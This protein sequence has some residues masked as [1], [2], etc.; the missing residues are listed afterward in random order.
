[1][2]VSPNRQYRGILRPTTPATH[3][4]ENWIITDIRLLIGLTELTRADDV[5]MGRAKR[6]Y[7][8]MIKVDKLIFFFAARYFLEEVESMF[9]VFLSSYTPY[10]K[11][12]A[13]M[14]FYC[15]LQI[16]PCC[17]VLKLEIQKNIFP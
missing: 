2:T 11:M 10:S 4:P 6:I 12:A 7:I 16:T 14:L 5:M 1:L 8:L 3:E 9:S 17:L 15:F 13:I